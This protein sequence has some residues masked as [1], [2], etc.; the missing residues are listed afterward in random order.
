[1]TGFFLALR[2]I[3]M[4]SM[5]ELRELLHKKRMEGGR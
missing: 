3:P 5:F 1:M 2:F 4:V